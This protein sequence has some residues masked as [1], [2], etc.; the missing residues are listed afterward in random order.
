MCGSISGFSI[1]SIDLF[2]Y[3]DTKTCLFDDCG[4]IEKLEGR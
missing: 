1:C 2:V 4:F 3:S